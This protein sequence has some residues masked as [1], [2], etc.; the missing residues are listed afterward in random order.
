MMNIS[1][2]SAKLLTHE[3]CNLTEQPEYKIP[4]CDLTI[5]A[6]NVLFGLPAQSYI[7]WLIATGAG[8]GIASEIFIL[9]VSICEIVFC[10]RSLISALANE[11]SKLWE[12]VMF[13]TGIVMTG[14][15]FQCVCCITWKWFFL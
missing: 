15:F 8:R 14:R 6:T 1:K 13:L 12:F 5:N 9:N 2:E 10:L 3:E 4:T 11:F 7:L